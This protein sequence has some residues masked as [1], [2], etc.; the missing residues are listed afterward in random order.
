MQGTSKLHIAPSQTLTGQRRAWNCAVSSNGNVAL[1]TCD[2][3]AVVWNTLNGSKTAVLSGH[4][5]GIVG[6][7]LSAKG[8]V[9]V[10]VSHDGSL[11]MW[12][13]DSGAMRKM[14]RV[15]NMGTPRDC[16]LAADGRA[17]FMTFAKPDNA[18]VRY[19]MGARSM[20]I[21]WCL[22]WRTEAYNC[23]VSSGGEVLAVAV[24]R[25]G[26]KGGVRLLDGK[27]GRILRVWHCAAYVRVGISGNGDRVL[28]ADDKKLSLY[29]ARDAREPAREFNGY[30]GGAYAHC[31]ISEDGRR[32]VARY[33]Q[34]DAGIPTFA[35]WDSDTTALIA[36]LDGHNG[37][38]NHCAINANG[39]KVLTTAT[40]CTARVW[41]VNS[42]EKP[43]LSDWRQS[44][45]SRV[46]KA[47]ELFRM[48]MREHSTSL[49]FSDAYV[50][51]VALLS[52]GGFHEYIAYPEVDNLMRQAAVN[53]PGRLGE[54]EFV[55]VFEAIA[56]RDGI[57]F[58]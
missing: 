29:R 40:D 46:Q 28:I 20:F 35:V 1:S 44:T 24:A 34:G 15:A 52:C 58:V 7:S 14:Q 38:P 56:R 4:A 39:T 42:I 8:Q 21:S 55:L 36:I 53:S 16:V 5:K 41:C 10:T 49:N 19:D 31:S 27:H 12:N 26:G 23:A 22:A 57:V 30:F 3:L 45:F 54:E 50:H 37:V 17:V 25:G 51:I 2:N 13:A 32:V 43:S 48:A 47:R 33:F 6:C 11:R 9:A 18:V